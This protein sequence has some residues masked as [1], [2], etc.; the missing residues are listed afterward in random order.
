MQLDRLVAD[1][2]GL[3]R[4]TLGEHIEV[5]HVP[6][7]G[8]WTTM[9]DPTQ[10]ENVLL[11]L[12]ISARDAMPSGGRLGFTTANVRLD[13]A[14]AAAQAD[15]EPGD[16]VV[17]QVTDTG[18]GIAPALLSRVFE[19]FFTTKEKGKGTG[20]GLAMAYGFVKQSRGHLGIESQPGQGTTVRLFLPAHEQQDG[21]VAERTADSAAP[22]RTGTGQ[23]VLL[24][25]DDAAVRHF[26]REQLERLG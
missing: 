8:L 3:I 17:L 14:G 15:L 1:M 19:P 21:P 11:N 26:A 10:L 22:A 6:T 4:R 25:E 12:A 20:L 13:A 9:V 5:T 2:N 7:P 23:C 24:V 18:C 16:C